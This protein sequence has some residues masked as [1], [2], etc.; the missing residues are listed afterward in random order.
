[1]HGPDKPKNHTVPSDLL[2]MADVV[3]P[4]LVFRFVLYLRDLYF[5][6]SDRVSHLPK[7]RFD[8]KGGEPLLGLLHELCNMGGA[9]RTVMTRALTDPMLYQNHTDG[10]YS[11][12]HFNT[13][14]KVEIKSGEC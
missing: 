1:M 13:E 10:T 3:V 4:R 11:N 12:S 2:P 14:E 6:F 9:M 5:K 7:V 8:L